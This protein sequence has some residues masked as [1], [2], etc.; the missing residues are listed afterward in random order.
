[1]LLISFSISL[2]S[3]VLNEKISC[4]SRFFF[5]SKE[6]LGE[7]HIVNSFIYRISNISSDVFIDI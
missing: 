4:F 5:V 2:I 3:T 6:Y 7:T 1:M